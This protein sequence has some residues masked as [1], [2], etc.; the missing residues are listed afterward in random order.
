MNKNYH[1]EVTVDGINIS[2]SN[3]PSAYPMHWHT[4]AEFILARE[5]NCHYSINGTHYEL[6]AGDVLLIWPAE[7]HEILYTPHAASLLIQ[8]SSNIISSCRDFTV[9]YPRLQSIHK[10]SDFSKELN[11]LIAKEL[12]ACEENSKKSD[13]FFESKAVISIFNMLI[14]SC[15]YIRKGLVNTKESIPNYTSDSF[16]KIKD[17]CNYI[18]K[19]CDTNITQEEVAKFCNF[20]TYYFSRL[21]HEYTGETFS[22]YVTRQRI[23]AAKKLL[24]NET[25]PITDVAYLAGFQ[26]IS[27][28]NKVFKASMNCS[29]MQYRKMYANK[30][31]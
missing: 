9:Y 10:V 15:D 21:F 20:S 13:P 22:S 14:S 4:Q 29:P 24:G 2:S 3:T 26:S 23:R 7:L 28:F 19:R 17:A 27:N 25:I 8:F 31:A 16:I 5:D 6:D 11:D 18:T 1:E 12:L 30:E